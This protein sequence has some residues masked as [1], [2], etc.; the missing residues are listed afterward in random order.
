MDVKRK[1]TMMIRHDFMTSDFSAEQRKHSTL[2][3]NMKKCMIY[4]E[5]PWKARWDLIMTL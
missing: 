5:N 4:P 3:A 2:R 1:K